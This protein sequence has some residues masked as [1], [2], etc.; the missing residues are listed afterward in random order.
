VSS[1]FRNLQH[2]FVGPFALG[3]QH[4]LN[5]FEIEDLLVHWN[6][7]NI[8]NVDRF[9]RHTS[10]QNRPQ[11][12]PPP[13]RSTSRSDDEWEVEEILDHRG[14]TCKTCS[15]KSNGLHM[16][17]RGSLKDTAN[18]ILKDYHKKHG[19]RIYK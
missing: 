12:P 15:T 7:H 3:K 4:G 19:L 13:M 14:S 1:A 18:E 11:Q 5:A 2:R 17:R 10:D 8:F 9:K 6:L 16:M